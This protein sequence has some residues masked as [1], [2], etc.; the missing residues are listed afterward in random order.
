VAR[1][2]HVPYTGRGG[3]SYKDVPTTTWLE[4]ERE[5]LGKT[6]N[7]GSKGWGRVGDEW[8]NITDKKKNWTKPK[9]D[10]VKHDLKRQ[11]RENIQRWGSVTIQEGKSGGK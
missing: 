5:K 3:G 1:T 9:G 2:E 7:R 10:P 4:L 8:K 11:M 6:G